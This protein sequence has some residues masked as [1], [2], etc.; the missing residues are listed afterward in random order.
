MKVQIK[1]FSPHQTAK[2][3]AILIV[4]S[5]LLIMIPMS[6][7][8]SFGPA[9]VDQS[10]NE[11]NVGFPFGMMFLVMPIIQGL[12]GYLMIRVGIWVYNKLYARIGGIEFEFE[13]LKS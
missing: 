13:D 5:M 11:I 1:N 2:V 8:V 10:G 3:F 12:F 7:I 9:P 4:V 6:L